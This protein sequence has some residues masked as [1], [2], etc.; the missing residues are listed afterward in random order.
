MLRLPEKVCGF[1]QRFPRK[2]YNPPSRDAKGHAGLAIRRGSQ[3]S[4]GRWS[5]G[6]RASRGH[7]S[8]SS[9]GCET[10]SRQQTMILGPCGLFSLVLAILLAV[11]N[12]AWAWNMAGHRIKRNLGLLP[13][14]IGCGLGGPLLSAAVYNAWATPG[15]RHIGV[16]TCTQDHEHALDNYKRRGFQVFK[17]QGTT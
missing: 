7:V 16:H 13:P 5:I 8:K 2:W 11:P 3:A 6:S 1:Y 12:S 15:A 14:F 17:I 4:Q 9:G 10:R